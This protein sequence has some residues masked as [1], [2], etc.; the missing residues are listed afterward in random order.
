MVNSKLVMIS[1]LVLSI[2]FM[3]GCSAIDQE[4]T[5]K[6]DS[7]TIDSENQDADVPDITGQVIATVNGE[8][9]YSQEVAQVQQSLQ[10]Q[11]QN[12]SQEEVLGQ[13]IDQKILFQ[14]AQQEEYIPS[15]EEAESVIV[16]QLEQQGQ[17][18][19]LEEYKTQLQ[20]M[21]L[22]YENELQGVKEQLAVQNYIE[23]ETLNES[24]EVTEEEIETF[25]TQYK[26]QSPQ[27]IPS[28]EELKPQLE[29]TLKQQKQQDYIFLLIQDLKENATIEIN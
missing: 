1:V 27:E 23:T 18:M 24:F 17:G 19:T 21:G 10:S 12:I 29:A 25:Y 28:L 7:L 8:E 11:G 5:N 22:S 6:T 26:E 15:D 16:S 20:S 9:I 2:L 3:V 14:E 4:E 13:L